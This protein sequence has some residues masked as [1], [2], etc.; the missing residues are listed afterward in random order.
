MPDG[1]FKVNFDYQKTCE[2]NGALAVLAFIS[3]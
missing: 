3:F 1:D 2:P